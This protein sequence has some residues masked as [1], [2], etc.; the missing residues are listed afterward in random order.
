MPWELEKLGQLCVDYNVILVSDE[1]HCDLV[2]PDHKHT[3]AALLSEEIHNK[4]ITCIA[5]SKTFNLAGLFT[6]SVVIP[7]DSWR[8]RLKMHEE[9]IHLPSNI[10]GITASEAAYRHGDQW[11]TELLLYLQNNRSLVYTVLKEHLPVVTASPLEATYLMWLDFR[12]LGMTEDQLKEILVG[13]AGVGLQPGSMFGP[14]G[15]GFMRLNIGCPERVLEEV[16]DRMIRALKE[17]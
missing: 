14:G 3:P 6:A 16:L 4:T 5:T 17:N 10:F 2:M 11:L 15:E 9:R 12:R 8:R 1:I 13:K 7:N